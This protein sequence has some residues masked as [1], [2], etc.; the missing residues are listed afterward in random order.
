M[1]TKNTHCL[2]ER[3]GGAAFVTGLKMEVLRGADAKEEPC[4]P[5]S[6]CV[7]VMCA[8]VGEPGSFSQ[9]LKH[10][11]CVCLDHLLFLAAFYLCTTLLGDLVCTQDKIK[12]YPVCGL[13]PSPH[14]QLSL[15]FT[16]RVYRA[17]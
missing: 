8:K 2:L 10:R 5:V 9:I 3:A 16:E 14:P 4:T 11:C 17:S 6:R 7:E 15:W 12:L 1:G 13:P